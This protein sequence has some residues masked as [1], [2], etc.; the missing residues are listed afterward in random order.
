MKTARQFAEFNANH[1]EVW[2]LFVRFTVE[3]IKRGFQHHSARAVLHRIRWE[4]TAP[5]V[6][7]DPT[8]F[9]INNDYSA[10]FARKFH[11]D[12]PQHDGFFRLREAHADSPF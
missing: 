8:G 4:T 3:L 12:F 2:R 9:K 5:T 7:D 10:Y 6:Q 1:P 11:Q